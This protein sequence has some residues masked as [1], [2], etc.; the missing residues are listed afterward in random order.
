MII[1][2]SNKPRAR[3]GTRKNAHQWWGREVHH[4]VTDARDKTLCGRD[5]TEWLVISGISIR[6]ATLSKNCC[7]FCA[8]LF[9]AVNPSDEEPKHD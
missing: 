6:E 7:V 9:E 2:C 3:S 8:R 1:M 5:A 4:V